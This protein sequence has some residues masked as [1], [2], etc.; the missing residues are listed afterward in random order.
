L[1]PPETWKAVFCDGFDAK[2]I[3]H[4]LAEREMLL[5]DHEDKTSRSET[6]NGKKERVY[7]LTANIMDNE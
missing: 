3:A 7:V 5:R 6:I 1:I 2:A 4:A